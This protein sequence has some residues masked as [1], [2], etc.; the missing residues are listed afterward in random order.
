MPRVHKRKARKDYPGIKKGDAYYYTKLR[1]SYGGIVKRSLT[2]FRPSQLTQSDFYGTWYA[3]QEALEDTPDFGADD[4]SNAADEIR[5]L[6]QDCQDKYDN[7][8][9]NFQYTET[10]ELLENR[11]Q[12]CDRIADELDNQVSEMEGATEEPDD[13]DDV[14]KLDEIR[15][16]VSALLGDTPE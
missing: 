3:T 13:P 10:G 15:E 9:E 16:T 12:E 5:N 11:A 8:P 4:I 1:T 2:P 14:S 7:L 6:G